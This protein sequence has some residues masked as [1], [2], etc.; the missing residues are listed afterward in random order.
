MLTIT[1]SK[2]CKNRKEIFMV[3]EWNTRPFKIVF[4]IIFIGTLKAI[5]HK[6]MISQ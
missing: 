5:I 3:F 6:R 1:L 2:T 4:F